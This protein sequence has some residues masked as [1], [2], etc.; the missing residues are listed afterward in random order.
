MD[1]VWVHKGHWTAMNVLPMVVLVWPGCREAVLGYI[2][3][4][5]CRA[6]TSREIAVTFAW[7]RCVFLL[8]LATSACQPAT[9]RTALTWPMYWYGAT[10][11]LSPAVGACTTLPPPT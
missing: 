10:L 1:Q 5:C 2:Q 4:I 6:S 8:L 7:L 9:R 3:P 11:T